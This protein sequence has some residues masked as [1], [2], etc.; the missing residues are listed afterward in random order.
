MM[1]LWVALAG[2]VGAMARYAVDLALTPRLARPGYAL[3]LI[4]ISGSL[5]IGLLA[6][7]ITQSLIP[8]A[9]ATIAMT[10]FLGGYTTFSA[11]SLDIL[12]TGTREGAGHG[13]LRALAIPVLAVAACGLGFAVGNLLG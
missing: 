13:L 8:T 6:G 5:L 3:A 10:G 12:E 4:N 2:G 1:L 9:A 7:L 11:A